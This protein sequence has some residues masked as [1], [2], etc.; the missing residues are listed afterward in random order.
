M[1]WRSRTEELLAEENLGGEVARKL[2]GDLAYRSQDLEGEAELGGRTGYQRSQ[3]ETTR[4]K[5]ADGDRL[6]EP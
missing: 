4:G 2:L 5:A 1:R 3:C 6:F